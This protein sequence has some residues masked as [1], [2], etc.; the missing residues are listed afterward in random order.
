MK[1]LLRLFIF[2]GLCLSPVSALPESQQITI[3]HALQVPGEVLTPGTYTFSLED[4]LHGRAIVRIEN[5][6][7]SMHMLV[8]TVPSLKVSASHKGE[9]IPFRPDASPQVLR[10]WLC[11]TCAKP[12]EFVYPKNEAV[13]I[14]ADT[15][16]S[17]LAADPAYDKLPANLSADDMRVVTLWLLSPERIT[18]DHGIGLAAVKYAAPAG[19]PAVPTRDRLPKTASNAYNWAIVGCLALLAFAILKSLRLRSEKCES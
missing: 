1:Q 14:T 10:A 2:S 18:N 11:A 8:L 3:D 5:S 4:R 17:V 9:L 19:M 13:K 7:T 12:L 6:A 16:Q 15:G